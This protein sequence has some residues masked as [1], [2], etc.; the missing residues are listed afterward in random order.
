MI[1]PFCII[2]Y[3]QLLSSITSYNS[4]HPTKPIEPRVTF[5]P[6]RLMPDLPKEDQLK[7][8]VLLKRFGKERVEQMGPVMKKRL[9]S[10]GVDVECVPSQ[11]AIRLLQGCSPLEGDLAGLTIH[12]L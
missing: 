5:H 11:R 2:G 1:C 3:R 8:D 10:V 6:Y 9:E 7:Q 4:A 12:P